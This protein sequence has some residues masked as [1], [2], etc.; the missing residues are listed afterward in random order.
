MA[1]KVVKVYLPPQLG[2]VLE[3]M[4]EDLGLSEGE[5]L[6]NLLFT[7]ALK[8]GYLKIGVISRAELRD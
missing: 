6:R 3:R 7:S 5:I 4:H 2:R 8:R 1:R